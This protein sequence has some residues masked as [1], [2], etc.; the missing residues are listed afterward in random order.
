MKKLLFLTA[1]RADYGKLKSI[2]KAV[3]SDPRF[4]LYIFVTGMHMIEKFGSTAAEI[5]VEKFSNIELDHDYYYEQ[6]MDIAISN[7]IRSLSRYVRKIKPDMIIV[8]GDRLDAIAG[9]LVGAFNNILVGHI[10]GGEVSGTIDESIRH[11]ISKFAHVHFVA[12]EEAKKRLVQM[13]EEEKAIHVIGSPDI[14]IMLSDSLPPLDAVLSHYEIKESRYAVLLYHSVVTEV[15]ET[16]KHTELILDA[17]RDGGRYVVAIYPNNDPGNEDI[18]RAYEKLG[19]MFRIIPSM[20]FEYFLTL[21]R[22]ADFIIGNSSAGIREACV[23]G[24]PAID[25]GSRQSGRYRESV[26]KNVVHTEYDL[27]Q[28]KRAIA[29]VD[30]HRLK[31]S[32]FGNGESTERF[33]RLICD[34]AVWNTPQQKQFKDL[35]DWSV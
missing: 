9:A 14:D 25:I 8:H 24:T 13:G 15:Q 6:H 35:S 17:L 18:R 4:E 12:N 2:L 27:P 26:L 23:Y 1:T 20:R 10:E 7:V 19:S 33:L 34:D 3:E 30:G 16:K 21:L 22:N 11:A 29:G 5:L 31:S 28:I 32:Y